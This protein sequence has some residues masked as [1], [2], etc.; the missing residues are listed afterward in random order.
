MFLQQF[1]REHAIDRVV[2]RSRM[3]SLRRDSSGTRGVIKILSLCATQSSCERSAAI[4]YFEFIAARTSAT[5]GRGNYIS[6]LGLAARDVNVVDVLICN[7][8]AQYIAHTCGFRPLGSGRFCALVPDQT[9]R[10]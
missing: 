1:L 8:V 2:L 9:A 5:T 3:F 6:I 7:S 4:Y 10:G